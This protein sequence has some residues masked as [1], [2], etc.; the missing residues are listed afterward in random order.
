MESTKMFKSLLMAMLMSMI[1]AIP[2]FAEGMVGEE[3]NLVNEESGYKI[4][5]PNFIEIKPMTVESDDETLTKTIQVIVMEKP[6]KNK[7]GKYPMFEI[8]ASDPTAYELWSNQGTYTNTSFDGQFE[9]TIFE[10][11]INGRATV[12]LSK[13]LDFNNSSERK[14][15]SFFL[16]VYD[17][18]KNGLNNFN[19]L[20]FTFGDKKPSEQQQPST[21]IQQPQT[22][23]LSGAKVKE[24][25]V[26]VPM[27]SLFNALNASVE[28]NGADQSVKSVREDRTIQVKI[29]SDQLVVNGI[30]KT[31]DAK[32]F[33]FNGVTYLP[34]R[35]VSEALGA[36][37]KWDGKAA[38]ITLDENIITVSVK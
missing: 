22:Q 36:T 21:E 8:V 4:I 1:L 5:I 33:T 26:Y 35:A 16:D 6:A 23:S 9:E 20:N 12:S 34:L 38:T 18:D 13:D 19:D 3:F 14:I 28:W 7:D 17:K 10:K 32:A 2:V 30:A 29:G 37:V 15:L 24:N 25:R 11:F 27:R 31:M